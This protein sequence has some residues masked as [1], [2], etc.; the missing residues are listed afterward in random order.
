MEKRR[1]WRGEGITENETHDQT[2]S[3]AHINFNEKKRERERETTAYA[4]I[5]QAKGQR[6]RENL[7]GFFI[8]LTFEMKA[9]VRPTG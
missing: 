7:R 5:R 9:V 3:Q 8:S 4:M 6:R 1:G 2:L